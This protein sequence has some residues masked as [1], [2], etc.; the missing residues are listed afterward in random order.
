[1]QFTGKTGIALFILLIPG[2][3]CPAQNE[4]ETEVLKHGQIV[5]DNIQTAIVA[6]IT[7]DANFRRDKQLPE[8]K[9]N[10]PKILYLKD[11][12]F[13]FDWTPGQEARYLMETLRQGLHILQS[14]DKPKGLDII[15]LTGAREYWPKLRDISCHETPGIR[16]Y[17]LDG[18]EQYCPAK[19]AKSGSSE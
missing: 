2:V 6:H 19:Q 4:T 1:M 17:D 15:A 8:D 11:G 16:Y 13:V 3:W 14:V 18:F 12:S 7:E 9:Q 10:E 5:A